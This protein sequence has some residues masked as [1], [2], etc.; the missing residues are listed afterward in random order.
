MLFFWKKNNELVSGKRDTFETLTDRLYFPI[1]IFCVL[2]IIGQILLIGFSWDRLP[3]Q[4]PLFYSRPW[5]EK[6]L[7]QTFVIWAL[8]TLSLFLILINFLGAIVFFRDNRFL[9]LVLVI[10]SFLIAFGTFYDTLK[11]I[12]LIS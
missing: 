7:A 12:T 3:P 5:G 8:P 9:S 1:L 11:I 10:F 4:V 2:S 6:M